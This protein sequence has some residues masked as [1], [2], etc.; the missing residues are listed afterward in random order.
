MLYWN[1]IRILII[2][3]AILFYQLSYQ[4][5]N[6]KNVIKAVIAL[7]HWNMKQKNAFDFRSISMWLYIFFTS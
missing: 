5:R 3:N 1:L 7:K 2:N 6:V 4:I